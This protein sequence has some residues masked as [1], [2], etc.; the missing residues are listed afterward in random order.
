LEKNILH[1]LSSNSKKK[2]N[3]EE[4]EKVFA[5]QR[6]RSRRGFISALREIQ[7]HVLCVFLFS[8]SFFSLCV[9]FACAP[10]IFL[11][12]F[13]SWGR[14]CTKNFAHHT[15]KEKGLPNSPKTSLYKRAF[16][17]TTHTL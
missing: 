15:Q 9:F 14:I 16:R 3:E 8:F 12:F 2:K 5:R 7:Y 11:F 13:L 10:K 4:K 1:P 17:H 6:D